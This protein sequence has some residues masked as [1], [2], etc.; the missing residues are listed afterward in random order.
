MMRLNRTRTIIA[1]A[2]FLV[3][4]VPV[5]MMLLQPSPQPAVEPSG[6][7]EGTRTTERKAGVKTGK[8][9]FMERGVPREDRI[10]EFKRWIRA[11]G[12]K[13]PD[14]QNALYNFYI[15]LDG[16]PVEELL[17]LVLT[18]FPTEAQI[19]FV[20]S[21]MKEATREDPL[22]AARL[23]AE[24]P[25]GAT[26]SKAVE[27][28]AAGA[29]AKGVDLDTFLS[30]VDQLDYP[31]DREAAI[32]RYLDGRNWGG[33]GMTDQFAMLDRLQSD[34]QKKLALSLWVNQ[35]PKGSSPLTNEQI[36][37]IL[38]KIGDPRLKAELEATIHLRDKLMA[39]EQS[40][41]SGNVSEQKGEPMPSRSERFRTRGGAAFSPSAADFGFSKLAGLP[42]SAQ[43]G[44][45]EQAT[46]AWFSKV[47]N[48][49]AEAAMKVF[50]E[51]PELQ[52]AG[53]TEYLAIRLVETDRDQLKDWMSSQGKNPAVMTKGVESWANSNS[54]EAGDW[55]NSLP[56]GELQRN[57]ATAL[58]NWLQSKGDTASA[59]AVREAFLGK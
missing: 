12:A 26:L 47:L 3:V 46:G 23:L 13:G 59:D 36:G 43:P 39:Q 20:D 29:A 33:V 27:V 22:A 58:A 11:G 8:Y 4:A 55:V 50:A 38:G 6:S 54:K 14:G 52:T 49:D 41:S 9:R 15:S 19:S 45:R 30:F 18:E 51:H 32:A 31:E 21:L 48:H 35:R 1:A 16:M 17:E 10:A 40:P 2:A 57:A 5:L 25:P 42:A 24:M 34:A 56:P 37:E 44:D 7:G 28:I 53:L